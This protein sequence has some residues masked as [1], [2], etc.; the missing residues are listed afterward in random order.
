MPQMGA[1]TGTRPVNG[2]LYVNKSE[3]LE[4]VHRWIFGCKGPKRKVSETQGMLIQRF[5]DLVE[6]LAL[7]DLWFSW[8][9][10][11]AEV[12]EWFL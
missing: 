4:N 11:S 7:W 9:D 10:F 6:E 8:F 1:H 5:E 2:L 12:V 3:K